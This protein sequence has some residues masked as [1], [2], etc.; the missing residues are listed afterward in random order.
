MVKFI[1]RFKK[2]EDE[3]SIDCFHVVNSNME[4]MELIYDMVKYGCF[5]GSITSRSE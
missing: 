5:S 4:W 2:R 3:A 1:V